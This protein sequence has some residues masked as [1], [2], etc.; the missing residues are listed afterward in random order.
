ML[1]GTDNFVEMTLFA[2]SRQE[3]LQSQLGFVLPAGV[4]S[5]DTFNRVLA[6]LESSVL[7]GC[8][9]GWLSQW[10][11]RSDQTPQTPRHLSIDGK[12]A[13]GSWEHQTNVCALTMVGVFANELRLILCC[14]QLEAQGGENLLAPSLLELLDLEG[15]LVTGDAA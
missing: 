3:F 6:A 12:V 1:C 4:P 2:R 13:L 11:Q 5:H 10:Q 9:L 14:G 7:G 8:L 15:A